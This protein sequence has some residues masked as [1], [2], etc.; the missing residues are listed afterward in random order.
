MQR[1]LDRKHAIT[2][3]FCSCFCD[4]DLRWQ[5]SKKDMFTEQC[6]SSLSTGY[7]ASAH[8]SKLVTIVLLGCPA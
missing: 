3:K 5:S 7:K 1:L 6:S 2:G 8:V 4:D